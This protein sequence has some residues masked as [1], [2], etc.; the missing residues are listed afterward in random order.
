MDTLLTTIP[1]L[2]SVIYEWEYLIIENVLE[3]LR[4]IRPLILR[5]ESAIKLDFL[6]NVQTKSAWM[7]YWTSDMSYI[8][9]KAPR[10]AKNITLEP[11]L[12]YEQ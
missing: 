8:L 11:C 6:N 9:N 12:G 4:K 2:N 1:A 7:S 5:D 3:D 10:K